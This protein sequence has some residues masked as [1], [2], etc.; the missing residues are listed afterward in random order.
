[1]KE[2]TPPKQDRAALLAA[3]KKQTP[4]PQGELARL[5][6]IV[7]ASCAAKVLP[8]DDK[9]KNSFAR[10]VSREEESV[11]VASRLWL[12]AGEYSKKLKFATEGTDYSR[13][14]HV[15][16][17]EREA[18]MQQNGAEWD[19]PSKTAWSLLGAYEWLKVNAEAKKDQNLSYE[20]FQDAWTKWGNGPRLMIPIKC[21]Q[22]FIAWRIQ[23]RSA[24]RMRRRSRQNKSKKKKA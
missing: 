3:M 12:H 21:L 18:S 20:G 4:P 16:G 15:A 19:D 9:D 2:Q 17:D 22:E 24:A 23:Q 10:D 14:W 11:R 8:P 5:A 13:A 7:F 1:M 6:A